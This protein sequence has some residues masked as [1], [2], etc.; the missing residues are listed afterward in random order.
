MRVEVTKAHYGDMRKAE[1]VAG[2]KLKDLTVVVPDCINGIHGAYQ[3]K[4]C[5][6]TVKGKYIA[7]M[8]L[9]E[10]TENEAQAMLKTF[11]YMQK[12][13]EKRARK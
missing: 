1:K 8:L 10:K 7:E 13:R 5:Y 3:V 6:R 9:L 12:L 2:K 4:R 11:Q